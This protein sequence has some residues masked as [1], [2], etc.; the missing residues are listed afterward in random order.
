MTVWLVRH[1]HA[2]NRSAWSGDDAARPLSARGAAQ[3]SA[4]AARLEHQPVTM[5]LSS[6]A[7][8]CVETVDGL[9]ERRG[10]PVHAEPSLAEG[11]DPDE[12]LA[13]LLGAARSVDGDLVACSHGDLIPAMVRRLSATGM[14]AAMP[15]AVEKGSVWELEVHDGEVCRGTYHGAPSVDPV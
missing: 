15:D 4:I 14:R 7:S 1:A 5:V 2:G 8:R 6:P 10:V 12:A 9:A 3:A 13:C 11:A